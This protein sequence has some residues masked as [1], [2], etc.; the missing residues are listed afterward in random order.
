MCCLFKFLPPD[1]TISKKY[2]FSVV[3]RLREA[4][5]LKRPESWRETLGSCT[6]TMH[7]VTLHWFFVKFRQKNYMAPQ[8]LY[9]PDLEPFDL[10]IVSKFKKPHLFRRTLTEFGNYLI[11]MKIVKTMI[12]FS[13]VF[14]SRLLS[15]EITQKFA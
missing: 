14:R 3:H 15:H 7:C 10:W 6:S 1:Q 4:I 5:R 12:L 2:Y 9:L 11:L 8:P 13:R